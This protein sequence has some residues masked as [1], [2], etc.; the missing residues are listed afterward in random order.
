MSGISLFGARLRVRTLVKSADV[1][2][3]SKEEVRPVQN[4]EPSL[5]AG[6]THMNRF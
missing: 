5:A 6:V 3:E 2:R 4:A 1:K